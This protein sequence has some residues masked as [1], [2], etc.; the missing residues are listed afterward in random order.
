MA[1]RDF[2]PSGSIR[3]GGTA[4]ST[5]QWLAETT[6]VCTLAPGRGEGN[7]LSVT[8]IGTQDPRFACMVCI[9]Q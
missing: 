8:I 1:F 3:L 4:C 7:I 2:D 9:Y 5:T 6:M